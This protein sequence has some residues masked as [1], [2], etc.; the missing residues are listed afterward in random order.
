MPWNDIARVEYARRSRR[1]ASD[2]KDREWT[3]ISPFMPD[4]RGLG[5]PRTTDLRE[6][7]NAILYIASTG[8]PW[9]Y[10]PTEFPPLSTVQRYFYHWRDEGLWVAINNSL[11]M[12]ARELEGREASPTAGVID[13]QSVK[14]TEAG[15][16]CGYDADKKVKG[17]KRH[18]VVDTI[19]LMVGLIVHGAGV[20]DRDGAPL[21]LATIRQRWP[22]LRRIFADG[23]YHQGRTLE[24]ARLAFA[25]Q[26]DQRSAFAIADGMQLGVQA[27]FGP[28]DTSGNSPFLSRLAAVR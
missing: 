16:V 8:C 9:R 27:A 24:V 1:Y 3:L 28:S 6:V 25:E 26:H 2:L 10:L 7:M 4:R 11:V 14:T 22:W 5:R 18:I 20:Q 21:V 19:G 23:G 13:S 15:G 17:R 12:A